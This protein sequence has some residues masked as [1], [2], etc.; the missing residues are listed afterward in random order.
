MNKLFPL[1]A[2]SI[3]LLVLTGIQNAFAGAPNVGDFNCYDPERPFV[4]GNTFTEVRLSDQFNDGDDDI[5]LSSTILNVCASADKDI[6]S[7]PELEDNDSMSPFGTNPGHHLT[8]RFLKSGISPQSPVTVTLQNQFGTFEN[9]QVGRANVIISPA[10]K[11]DFEPGQA[12]FGV[13]EQHWLCYDI[14]VPLVVSATMT[15]QFT[16]QDI[17]IGNL[18]FLCNPVTKEVGVDVFRP[19]TDRHMACGVVSDASPINLRKTFTDQFGIVRVIDIQSPSSSGAATLNYVC[20]DTIKSV[21]A[22]DNVIGGK[23]IPIEATSLLLAGA[24]SSIIWI[25]PLV[26]VGAATVAFTIRKN[27]AKY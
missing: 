19:A 26:L 9:V 20:V 8:M 10:D 25:L 18:K 27:I 6:T 17:G 13:L 22:G 12:P 15:D 7:P 11:T 1:F 23:I 21:Q 4:D 5:V 2:F 16:R 24:Q 14:D 3:L